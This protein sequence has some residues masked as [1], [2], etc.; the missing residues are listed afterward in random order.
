MVQWLRDNA[1]AL[2]STAVAALLSTIAI[3]QSRKRTE[4]RLVTKVSYGF[5]VFGPK[6]SE[7]HLIVSVANDSLHPVTVRS[8]SLR[9]PGGCTVIIPPGQGEFNLPFELAPGRGGNFWV[10]IAALSG[11]LMEEGYRGRV[12]LRS[13]VGDAVGTEFVSRS[14]RFDI[15]G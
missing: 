8:I 13:V 6:L 1:L 14:I 2:V 15:K 12:K 10:S 7:Q 4:R 9:L 3:L 5:L 11:S